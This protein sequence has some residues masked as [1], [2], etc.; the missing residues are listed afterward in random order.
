MLFCGNLKPEE[1][2]PFGR[3]DNIKRDLKEVEYEGGV[4]L[5]NLMTRTNGGP[6]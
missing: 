6:V 4:D 3:E 1:K 5:I 2:R